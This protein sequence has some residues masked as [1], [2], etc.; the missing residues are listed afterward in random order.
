MEE[1]GE[2]LI[3]KERAEE[4][5]E[6]L[7]S[8]YPLLQT[9]REACPGTYKHAQALSSMIEGVSMAL[10]LDVD[11]MK[12][13]ALYHDVGKMF[14]P[15]YFTEN[16]LEGENP[17]DDLDPWISSQILSRHVSDSVNIL[18][19]DSKFPREMIQIISQ[20]HGDN[21]IKY[22][23]DEAGGDPEDVDRFRYKCS[24]PV[25][26][27]A[28]VLMICDHVEA[29]SRSLVQ[30]GKF[31]SSDAIDAT[32]TDLIDDGQLDEVYMR[33]GDLKKIKEAVAKELEGMYQKRIDYDEAKSKTKRKKKAE[34][35][36]ESVEEENEE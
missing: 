8:T 33:L 28:A 11:F 25:S 21:V 22:F 30:S 18:L 19:N 31:E 20:H 27:E 6:L 32:I 29:K 12:V 13:T 15:K 17:H 14:N 1:N 35:D 9:F 24:K 4:L 7:D 5:K 36:K 23:F 34:E 3:T 10:G 16:Q 26:V 2:S